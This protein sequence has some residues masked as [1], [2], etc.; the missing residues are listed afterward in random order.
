MSKVRSAPDF[1]IVFVTLLLL[2]IGIVM[3][4]SASA[5]FA[6]HKFQDPYFFTKRQ[7]IFAILGIVSMYVM[8]NIDYW[9]WKKWA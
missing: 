3:V 8:M 4:Y 6:Q 1:V 2:G 5:V 9:V 7:I